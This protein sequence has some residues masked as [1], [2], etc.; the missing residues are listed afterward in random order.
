MCHFCEIRHINTV[1]ISRFASVI[2]VQQSP[3]AL[4]VY[5]YD[6]HVFAKQNLPELMK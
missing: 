5:Q 3:E 1:F 6:H 4:Y 2:F